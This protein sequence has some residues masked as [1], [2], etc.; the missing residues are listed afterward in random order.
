[1][2]INLISS[3]DTICF[4]AYS[5][6]DYPVE[7]TV[8]LSGNTYNTS[9]NRMEYW[10]S[11]TTTVECATFDIPTETS[12]RIVMAVVADN[13]L[14]MQEFNYTFTASKLKDSELGTTYLMLILSNIVSIVFTSQMCAHRCEQ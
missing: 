10:Q 1:M 14:G 2:L 12:G 9:T 4:D 6:D 5:H 7:Y 11:T 13:A 3:N 8:S